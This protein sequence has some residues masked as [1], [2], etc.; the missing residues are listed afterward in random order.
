MS[1]QVPQRL[2]RHE[3]KCRSVI[4]K[5]F[6]KFPSGRETNKNT[7]HVKQKLWCSSPQTAPL[8]CVDYPVALAFF[9]FFFP[10]FFLFFTLYTLSLPSWTVS[11]RNLRSLSTKHWPRP[12][13]GV[14]NTHSLF[15]RSVGGITGEFCQDSL[16]FSLPSALYT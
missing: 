15:H 9:F 5:W 14:F 6:N 3:L 7:Q 12:R 16:D 2:F 10:S 11:H 8:M 13:S 1:R 4:T